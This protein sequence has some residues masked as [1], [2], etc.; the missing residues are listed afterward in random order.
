[1]DWSTVAAVA[2]SLVAVLGFVLV[3]GPKVYRVSRRVLDFLEDWNGREDRPGVPGRPGVIAQ[4]GTLRERV[5]AVE[6]IVKR[7]NP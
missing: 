1:M 6:T 5:D 7:S 4:L 3:V 2:G